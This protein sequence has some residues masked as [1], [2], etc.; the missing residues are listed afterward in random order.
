MKRRLSRLTKSVDDLF[1]RSTLPAHHHSYLIHHRILSQPVDQIEKEFLM[2]LAVTCSFAVRW[3]MI[4]LDSSGA[5]LVTTIV[6]EYGQA[7]TSLND[8]SLE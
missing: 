6:V 2:L 5:K 8:S 3:G 1:R 7:E 4:Q